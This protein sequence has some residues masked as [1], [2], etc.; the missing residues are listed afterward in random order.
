VT[1]RA[2]VG[3]NAAGP[4][5]RAGIG[6]R[7]QRSGD[8]ARAS[9]VASVGELIDSARLDALGRTLYLPSASRPLT[10]MAGTTLI[11][12]LLID[13]GPGAPDDRTRAR[14][15]AGTGAG[16]RAVDG[17][18]RVITRRRGHPA[19]AFLGPDGSER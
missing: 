11:A 17:A 9:P 5:R 19:R 8:E 18:P 7:H 6:R 15:D 13:G 1:A 4:L 14:G 10:R 16:P 2:S 3:F 12:D